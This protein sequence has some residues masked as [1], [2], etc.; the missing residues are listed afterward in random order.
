MKY[1]SIFF[2]VTCSMML[3]ACGG[4]Q[5]E[6]SNHSS[7]ANTN[8]AP[9]GPVN[10]SPADTPQRIKDMM[11]ARGEQDSAAPEVA[12]TAPVDGATVESSTVRVQLA[13]GGDLKGYRPGMDPETKMGNHIH[14]ILDNQAYEAYYNIEQE[15][16]LRN[17]PDGEHTL[18]VFA[19]RP[20]HESYKNEG[21]FDVVKFTV[22]NG[23]ANLDL[24]ATTNSGQQ[25]SNSNA[26]AN[27]NA[28]PKPTPEGKDMPVSTGGAI[29][30][31][32]PLLTYSRPKGEYKAADADPIMIDFWLANAKLVGD[33]GEYRVRYSVNGGE[34]KMIEKWAPLWLSGWTAG[35]HTIKLELVDKDGNVVDNG[36]YNSTSREITVVK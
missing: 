2:A 30:V 10:L 15:F 16:E 1:I 31:K 9:A 12:I 17:V 29:D 19:S 25:M 18:R 4:A 28:A 11:A 26:N 3:I 14:V 20:W 35:K 23:E 24:P 21:A 5:T 27:T 33:G 7:N 6:H 13:V 36:G 32:K 22:K 8:A 34:P